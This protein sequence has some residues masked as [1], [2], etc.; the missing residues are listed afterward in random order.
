MNN[1]STFI[2]DKANPYFKKIIKLKNETVFTSLDY[3]GRQKWYDETCKLKK[4]VLQE[5]VRD[6]N[7]QKSDE[8][9]QKV[10]DCRKDYKYY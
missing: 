9:R 6:F 1:F 5:A 7:L 4:Q 3:K 8:N 2:T 10:F